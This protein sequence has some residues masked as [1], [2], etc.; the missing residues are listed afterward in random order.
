MRTIES[1]VVIVLAFVLTLAA[2]LAAGF[3]GAR[4][5]NGR[6]VQAVAAN[7]PLDELQLTADQTQHM[8]KI[9]ESVRDMSQSCL[10]RGQLLRQQR[11]M[12]MEALLT[13]DQKA[14]FEKV[15]QDYE[16]QVLALNNQRDQAF[17]N[18]VKETEQ[19]L[20]DRQRRL[21]D[22]ILQKNTGR[23]PHQP[24]LEP[25]SASPAQAAIIPR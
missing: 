9:W 4:Y 21:Y 2:G 14:R 20:N 13:D 23:D 17:H 1:H 18:A 8:R 16:A 15:N 24:L 12:A 19:M 3:W 25:A 10:T 7:S 22:A 11:D 6:P 5:L